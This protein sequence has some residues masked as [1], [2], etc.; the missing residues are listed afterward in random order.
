MVSMPLHAF[1]F[2]KSCKNQGVDVLCNHCFSLS[3]LY[4]LG[5][6]KELLGR[7]EEEN[8]L[9]GERNW[10]FSRNTLFCFCG[11]EILCF[12]KNCFH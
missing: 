2:K 1:I 12:F 5:S 9:L 11:S 7:F 6:T 4:R 10:P 3:F 8:L